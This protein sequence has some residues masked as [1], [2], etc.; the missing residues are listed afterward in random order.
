MNS[1]KAW[2]VFRY[3]SIGCSVTCLYLLPHF[4]LSAN[5]HAMLSPCPADSFQT[6]PCSSVP[7]KVVLCRSHS[8]GGLALPGHSP[9][10]STSFS[11]SVKTSLTHLGMLDHVLFHVHFTQPHVFITLILQF[12]HYCG[13]CLLHPLDQVLVET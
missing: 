10:P 13:A 6:M 5:W 7:S 9:G 11:S 1:H 2:K 12:H 4:L 3:R 8:R